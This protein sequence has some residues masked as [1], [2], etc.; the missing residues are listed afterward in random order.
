MDISWSLIP[1]EEP[2][3]IM[4]QKLLSL[5]FRVEHLHHYTAGKKSR[6]RLTR[7]H[8]NQSGISWLQL[9]KLSVH[10]NE[11]EYLRGK[12]HT[13]AD[14]L[15]TVSPLKPKPEDITENMA[16]TDNT[17][18]FLDY[19]TAPQEFRE[20][21]RKNEVSMAF[22]CTITN[23]WLKERKQCSP[24]LYDYWN[25]QGELAVEN[26]LIFK[27]DRLDVPQAMRDSILRTLYKGHFST[28]KWIFEQKNSVYWPGITQDIKTVV[29]SC[30]TCQEKAIS[31]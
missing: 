26:S 9:L 13:I 28:E 19:A 17:T 29:Q 27:N 15:S 20:A 4:E 3:F 12:E 30:S 25:C 6:C 11:V 2:Y 22:K 7:N 14:T 16:M 8:W 24:V 23:R 10:D 5:V 31:Q 21:T 1:A 18:P